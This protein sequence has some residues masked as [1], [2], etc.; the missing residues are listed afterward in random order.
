MERV[1][2]DT[3]LDEVNTALSSGDWNRA[4]E[5]IEALRPPDQ[6]EVFHDLLAPDQDELLPRLDRE[7][8]AD[9]LEEL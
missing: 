9:I 1:D 3:I 6:A 4:V 5:L 2:T 7:D 8:S